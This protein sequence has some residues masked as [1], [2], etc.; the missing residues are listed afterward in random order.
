MTVA[1]PTIQEEVYSLLLD[2]LVS[3]KFSPGEQLIDR[4]IAGELNVSR[5]PVR[6]ALSRLAREGLIDNYERCGY[7]SKKFNADDIAMIYD[8]R[9]AIEGTAARLAAVNAT[10]PDILQLEMASEKLNHSLGTV[11][12]NMFS[13]YDKEFHSTIADIAMNKY[14]KQIIDNYHLLSV[15]SLVCIPIQ[16]KISESMHQEYINQRDSKAKSEHRRI[17]QAISEKNGEEAER[18]LREHII[19]AKNTWLRYFQEEN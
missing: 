18:L 13:F 7:F 1:P 15:I 17:L 5:T 16:S 9:E 8:V 12:A 3:G 19:D 2:K 4:K 6:E 10:E 11:D 14:L